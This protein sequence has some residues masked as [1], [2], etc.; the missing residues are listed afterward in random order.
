LPTTTFFFAIVFINGAKKFA[1]HI[2]IV[3]EAAN[4]QEIFTLLPQIQTEILMTD[5]AMPDRNLLATL[6][7]IKEQY[8]ELKIIINSML[9]STDSEE[10]RKIS[11]L[12]Q[13]WLCFYSTEEEFIK[14]I[15]I[16][17]SGGCYF[18]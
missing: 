18:V 15:Q 9:T 14:A 10:S 3:A 12:A 8:P 2:Q 6:P 17:H 5:D 1:P 16:V 4:F 13:G 7:L 11:E